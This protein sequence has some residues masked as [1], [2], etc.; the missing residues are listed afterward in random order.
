MKGKP[1]KIKEEVTLSPDIVE[2]SVELT[3]F[4]AP[5]SGSPVI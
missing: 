5:V 1:K 2:M 3:N 4:R